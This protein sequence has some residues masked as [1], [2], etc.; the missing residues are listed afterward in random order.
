[1][2]LTSALLAESTAEE[3][4]NLPSWVEYPVVPHLGELIFGIVAF[5][6]LYVVV[7]R[8][9]VPRLEELFAERAAAIE[10]GM[11][12]AEQ[13]QAEAA[14]ALEEYRS[15]LAEARQEASRIRAEAQAEGAAIIAELREQAQ[16]EAARITA[17]ANQQIEAARQQAVVQLRAE[18]GRLAIDLASRIV[19]ESL[20]DEARQRR[21]VER[22]LDDLDAAEPAGSVAAQGQ[23]A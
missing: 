3:G 23:D 8:K 21:V 11:E 12:K 18:V 2:I 9:V 22:F 17:G 16:T 6:I 4:T 7:A 19:G 10:G 5:L 1:V 20:E 15:R 13:A 14:A